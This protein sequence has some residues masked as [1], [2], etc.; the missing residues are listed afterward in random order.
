MPKN[1]SSNTFTWS[2]A[3]YM[4]GLKKN[5]FQRTHCISSSAPGM[6]SVAVLSWTFAL[7]MPGEKPWSTCDGCQ[8]LSAD[9]RSHWPEIAGWKTAWKKNIPNNQGSKWFETCLFSLAR[10]ILKVTGCVF[11]PCR[12]CC[13]TWILSSRSRRSNRP[14]QDLSTRK[15]GLKPPVIC[16]NNIYYV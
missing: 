10:A 15:R 13:F 3:P 14:V 5:S 12:L 11:L 2:R 9:V 6:F 7:P 1:K 8:V 16:M 4:L